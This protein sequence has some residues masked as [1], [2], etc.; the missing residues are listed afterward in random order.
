MT[1]YVGIDIGTQGTKAAVFLEDGTPI[2]D[3]YAEHSFTYPNPGWVEMDPEQIEAAVVAA[4]VGALTSARAAGVSPSDCAGIAL[5]GIVCGP[6]LIDEAWR[7][8][9]P[10]IPFL[11]M[12]AQDEVARI[13]LLGDLWAEECGTD[14]LDTYITP[15]T[16]HWVRRH[17]PDVYERVVKVVSLAPYIAGR[18]AGLDGRAAFTD[19]TH[20][21]GWI[22]GW[23]AGTADFSPGQIEALT[24]DPRILPKVVPSASVI[25]HLRPEFAQVTGMRVGTPIAAGAGDIMQSNLAAG[26]T[27]TGQATDVAGTASLL[28]VAVPGRDPVISRIPGMLYSLGTTPGTSFYWGYVKAGGLSL[29]WFRD[30]VIGRSGSD[31]AY[32]E[33]DEGAAQV[34]PGADGV[35]FLPYLSGGGPDLSEA[36]GTWLGL[37]A[38]SDQAVLWRSL[39]E[40]IAFEYDGFLRAF[41]EQGLS[42]DEVFAVGG[43]SRSGLWNQIKADVTGLPWRV[44][45]RQ[46]GAVLAN[47]ALA[48]V[49]SGHSSDV[50][51]LVAQWVDSG[52][53]A[54]PNPDATRAYARVADVRRRVLEEHLAPAFGPIYGLRDTGEE[55]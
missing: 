13:R 50:A 46:E 47:A 2:A 17:E 53:Q 49:A 30:Q 32:R 19:P 54:V 34:S 43:G 21:S 18:L 4:L 24:L 27:R 45:L 36:S 1:A 39:L 35:L 33:L 22:I 40:S 9:R 38:G 52:P 3:A 16:L 7:P 20:L 23:D 42:V 6:V 41:R 55:F 44:P 29:R 48:A 37:S 51:R 14:A 28:T 12:R 8:V 25:G 10:I 15:A 31:E 11:D 26:Q 5:S